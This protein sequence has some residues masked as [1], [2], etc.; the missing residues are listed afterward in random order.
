MLIY[1]TILL[2]AIM[3]GTSYIVE[4]TIKQ[5][6]IISGVFIVASA[7]YERSSALFKVG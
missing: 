3:G 2:A 7:I 1:S 5:L 4:D 6:L